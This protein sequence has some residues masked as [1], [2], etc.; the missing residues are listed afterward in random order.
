VL[1][2]FSQTYEQYFSDETDYNPF[3]YMAANLLAATL[4]D[5]EGDHVAD[6]IY[7][8][9]DYT[10]DKLIEK[11]EGL[12]SRHNCYFGTTEGDGS[13]FGFWPNEGGE[14]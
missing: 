1:R 2:R 4:D 6:H 10:I 7:E 8:H 3:L 14:A 9:V 13:D 11:L 5:L 12:A